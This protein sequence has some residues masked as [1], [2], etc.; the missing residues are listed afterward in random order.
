ML[1]KISKEKKQVI[2]LGDFNI[3]LLSPETDLDSSKFIDT[4]SS[5]SLKP[6]INCPTRVTD[7]TET[8]IDNII[9]S[10]TSKFVSGNLTV[11]ISDHLPQFTIL[12]VMKSEPETKTFYRDWKSLDETQFKKDFNDIDWEQTLQFQ[13]SDP[14]HSLNRFIDVI[15]SLVDTHIPMKA[16]TK[17]KKNNKTWIT[18]S[19]RKAISNRDKLLKSSHRAK[20][21]Q[22]KSEF[23]KQNKKVRNKL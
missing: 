13:L 21:V 9:V 5:F 15:N 6:T 7:T 22:E 20:T 19:I 23:F 10:E 14:D 17:T 8:L 3:N 2:L 4:I 1:D 12:D 11:G 16:L 18:K